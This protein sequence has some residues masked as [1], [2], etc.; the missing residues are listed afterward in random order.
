MRG[1]AMIRFAKR[2]GLGGVTSLTAHRDPALSLLSR[3]LSRF[4]VTATCPAPTPVFP[5]LLLFPSPPTFNALSSA[6]NCF[7]NSSI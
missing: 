7:S 2:R 3:H 5:S 6:I 4:G 1:G